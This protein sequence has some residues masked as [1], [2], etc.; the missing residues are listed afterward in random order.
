MF[1]TRWAPAFEMTPAAERASLR[2]LRRREPDG[3]TRS[4]KPRRDAGEPMTM[5]N[6]DAGQFEDELGEMDP[7][8]GAT[9]VSLR[10]IL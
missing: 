7:P 1:S 2:W 3:T 10:Q 8:E 6:E 5:K 9:N 4:A